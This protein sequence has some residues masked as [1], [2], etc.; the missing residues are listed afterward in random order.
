MRIKVAFTLIGLLASVLLLAQDKTFTLDEAVT[1]AYEHNREMKDAYYE[2]GK[3]SQDVKKQLASGLPQIS[4]QVKYQNFLALPVSL[5]PAEFFGGKP[6]EFAEVQFGTSNNLNASI[7]GSQMIFNGNYFVGLKAAEMYKDL[8]KKQY[9]ASKFEVRASVAKAY[10]GVLITRKNI[11][12]LEQNLRTLEDIYRE[13]KAMF[14]EGFIEEIEVDRLYLS[15]STLRQQLET[16]K[17]QEKLSL[18]LLKFQMGYP[19]E[20]EIVLS[21]SISAFVSTDLTLVES[22]ANFEHTLQNDILNQSI[23]LTGLNIKNLKAGYLPQADLFISASEN[24][25][26]NEFNFFDKNQPWYETAVWGVSLN[27]PIWDSFRKRSGIQKE[28]IS[29]RQMINKRDQAAE[30]YKMQIEQR[31]AEYLNASEQLDNAR[32][33]MELAKKIFDIS[34]KKYEEGVGS[35]LEVDNARSTYFNSSSNYINALYRLLLAKVEL[36]KLLEIK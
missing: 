8:S 36:E 9:E 20:D 35:S 1:Y 22:P 16:L 28:E 29:Q 27:I 25:Q 10:Y 12:I 33:N 6:G 17:R 5:I 13:S 34:V 24:A 21:D 3:A 32:S 19:Y 14:D 30:A 23:S 18:G 15:L 2:V 26:R 7:N 11:E 31:K 4:A